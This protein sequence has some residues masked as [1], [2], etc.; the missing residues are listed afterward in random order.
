MPSLFQRTLGRTT[1]IATLPACAL[2]EQL[3]VSGANF[4]LNAVL[5]RTLDPAA[6]GC[7]AT[8]FVCGL[9]AAVVHNGALL[10]PIAIAGPG[11]AP[12]SPEYVVAQL[13]EHVRL[14]AALA[15]LPLSAGAVVLGLGREPGLGY[16]LL[17]AGLTLPA[18]LLLSL[19]RRLLVVAGQPLR[20]AAAA[21]LYAGVVVTAS[22]AMTMTGSAGV[23]GAYLLIAVASLTGA[24]LLTG[25]CGW[26]AIGRA[27]RI[28]HV[29]RI[30]AVQRQQA[31]FLV[32]A[33][34]LTFAVTQMQVPAIVL[35][36]GTDQAGIYRAMQL[37]MVAVGQVITAAVTMTLPRLSAAFVRGDIVGI[38]IQTR[39][40]V[41]ILLIVCTIAEACL[42]LGHHRITAM[43]FDGKF[44]ESSWLMPVAGLVA[45]T[46]CW[47]TA[48]GVALRAMQESRT[49]L[50][51][52][53]ITTVVSLP[54][55][56]LFIARY[57]VAGAAVSAALSY[58]V[59][60]IVNARF[61]ADVV[62]RQINEPAIAAH[63][64]AAA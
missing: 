19:V 64:V 22:V 60:S 9:F 38:R 63:R 53:V 54:A 40:L 8:A 16:A 18:F 43:L 52:A 35:M 51:A 30:D 7:F 37:P 11:R 49:Q 15:V 14:C 6:Y 36:L 58:L 28:S 10:D 24:S 61:Y 17:M 21:M 12:L 13:W 32:P 29:Q 26:L 47:G 42:A 25:A 1:R 20:A 46:S 48:F 41:M 2:A 23:T 44:A 50:V 57:G 59:L 55:V 56:V 33:G 3:S 39:R 4:L 45:I 62:R 5:A 31:W 27:A 34:A